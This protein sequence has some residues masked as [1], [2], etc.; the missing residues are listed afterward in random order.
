MKLVPLDDGNPAT[1]E[2]GYAGSSAINSVAFVRSSVKT[3]GNQQFITWYGRHQ[4]DSAAAYN[5]TIWIGRR[6]LGESTW[7]VFRHPTFT[8]NTI[9]DGHDVICYGIDGDGYM[10]VSWGMHGD[11][12]HYSK[13]TTPVTGGGSISLGPDTTM[14]GTENTVTY[15]QFLKLPAGDLLFIFREGASGNG[16]T[17]INRYSIA[18]KTWANV[19]GSASTQNPFIK[20]TGWTPNYNAYL[21]MPQ[22]GGANGDDLIIT[23]SWRTSSGLSDAGTGFS[24]YQTN[25]NINFAR[26]TDAGLTWKRFG[27]SSYSLPIT[28]DLEVG[29]ANKAEIITT[30]PEGSSLIN[31]ASTCLDAND[32][33]VTC[34]W[35]APETASSNYRRQYRVVFRDDNGTATLADDT[36]QA[37][38]VSDRTTDPV[39]TRY[40]EDHVRDL[41]RPVIV[42]DDADRLIVSYRDNQG[43]PSLTTGVSNGLTIV[44]SLPK[45]DD[46]HRLVWVQFDLTTENLG[47]YEPIID[48][49][50]WDRERQLHFLYQAAEGQGY[51][52]PANL[53]SRFSVLEWDAAAY[54]A[55][56]P[57]P[58]VAFSADKTQITITCPSQPSWAY[59][60]SP[61]GRLGCRC[62]SSANARA[63]AWR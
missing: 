7:Q 6:T 29:A 36:W 24:G 19:H 38:N 17:Y 46:P 12:F 8:A 53:A 35:W 34:T 20:G 13:S 4:Y 9:T 27:G 21:N 42:A 26:S 62:G 45:A 40:A 5:N 22:L 52:A 14:T 39:G 41:G 16:D 15:P 50:L 33:P 3:V 25:N 49:E 57:Q 60:L 10:H 31:Q 37:R 59:R 30:I 61:I 1:S 23:W 58:G 2:F 11:A 47:N 54:F 55:H 48:N 44:H 32:N 63:H 28:R 18:T 56:Q 43:S 51:T